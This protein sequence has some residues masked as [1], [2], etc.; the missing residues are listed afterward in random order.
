MSNKFDWKDYYKLAIKLKEEKELQE[1]CLRSAISRAYY[2]LHNLTKNYA[3]QEL[4]D[5]H[6]DK[7]HGELIDFY[8]RKKGNLHKIGVQLDRARIA[9]NQCDYEDMVCMNNLKKKTRDVLDNETQKIIDFLS[10]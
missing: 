5:A 10:E 3:K 8:R 7:R 6:F 9:R 1:A 2:A 4:A